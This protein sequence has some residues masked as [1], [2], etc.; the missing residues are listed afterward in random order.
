[1]EVDKGLL[2]SSLSLRLRQPLKT[3][4][5]SDF[6]GGHAKEAHALLAYLWNNP[7]PAPR[8]SPPLTPRC[9]G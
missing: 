8:P 6:H 4:T 3:L 5:L 7:V 9:T 1:M 2:T